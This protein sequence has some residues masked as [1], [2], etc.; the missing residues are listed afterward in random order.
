MYHSGLWFQRRVAILF[1]TANVSFMAKKSRKPTI[2][3]SVTSPDGKPVMAYATLKQFSNWLHKHHAEHQGGWIQFFKVASGYP[4]ITYAQGL[5]V[6]LCY[7]WIYG[8]V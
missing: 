5:D 2:D 1:P 3:L 7:G 4:S 6:A 8:S